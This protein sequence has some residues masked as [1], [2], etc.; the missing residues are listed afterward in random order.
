MA[1]PAAS[2]TANTSAPTR[3]M[4]LT[5]V[6]KLPQ[7]VRLFGAA[8]KI[9]VSIMRR[10][11]TANAPR[12]QQSGPQ[13]RAVALVRQAAA[14]YDRAITARSRRQRIAASVRRVLRADAAA[15]ARGGPSERPAEQPARFAGDESVVTRP[16]HPTGHTRLPRYAPSKSGVIERVHALL[17]VE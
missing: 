16:I 10:R 4:T 12:M 5:I 7:W 3:I 9:A 6:Q 15:L 17:V 1:Q 8:G 2:A 11:A 14:W 13:R